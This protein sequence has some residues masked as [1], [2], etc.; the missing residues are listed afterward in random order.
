MHD[1]EEAAQM[2]L[3]AVAADETDVQT[4]DADSTS[5][6]RALRRMLI[7]TGASGFVTGLLGETSPTGFIFQIAAWFAFLALLV[8]W[9]EADSRQRDIPLWRYF[10]PMLVLFPGPALVMPIYFLR[11]RGGRGIVTTLLAAL[12]LIGLLAVDVIGA[13][14]G[15]LLSMLFGRPP[16]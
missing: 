12:F 11:S 2:N 6:R 3:E 13:V 1:S 4:P 14:A 5:K 9:C 7:W 16:L 10:I 8:G 15:T